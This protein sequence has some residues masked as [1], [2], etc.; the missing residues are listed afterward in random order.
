MN[1]AFIPPKNSRFTDY[2]FRE[3]NLTRAQLT[4]REKRNRAIR[5]YRDMGDSTL[6]EE[7]GLFWNKVDQERAREAQ[8]L[9]FSDNPFQQAKPT[10]KEMAARFGPILEKRRKDTIKNMVALFKPIERPYIS[11]RGMKGPL[12]T[13]EGREA[14]AGDELWID[15]FMSTSRHPGFAAECALHEFGVGFVIVEIQPVPEAETIVLDNEVNGRREYETIFNV[16]QKIRVEKSLTDFKADFHPLNKASVCY[17][18]TLG[19]G[20]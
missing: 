7:I 9:R 8:R 13:S 3:P 6:A 4:W 2:P 20:D 5:L 11:Y 18:V 10:G 16:G 17:A 1:E 14:R 15:G 12:L 19:P